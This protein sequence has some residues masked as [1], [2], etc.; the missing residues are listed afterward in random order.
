VRFLGGAL[1]LSVACVSPTERKL[2]LRDKL[3][4]SLAF[5]LGLAALWVTAV[6]A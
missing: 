5:G 1:L 4:Q 2:A 3:E 6:L